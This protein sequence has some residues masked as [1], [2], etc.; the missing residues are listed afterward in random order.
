MTCSFHYLASGK[1]PRDSRLLLPRTKRR[2]GAQLA[3]SNHQKMPQ[4][5]MLSKIPKQR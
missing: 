2:L 5:P 1:S 3:C 4:S